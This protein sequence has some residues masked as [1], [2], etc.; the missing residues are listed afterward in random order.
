MLLL[1]GAGAAAAQGAHPFGVPESGA[2]MGGPGWLAGFF[3]QVSAWQS[4][5]YRQLTGA[6][7]AWQADGG[8]AWALI[9]LSFAYGVFHALGP[10]HGKA[11]ISSYVLA[12]RQTARNGALLALASALIQALVAIALVAVL[13]LVFN[14]TAATMNNATRWL[15]L[16]SYALVTLL[17]VW[18]VW[19]KA[20]RPLWRAWAGRAAEGAMLHQGHEHGSGH[21][22]SRSH[23]SQHVQA[24]A[25]H[26][27]GRHHDHDCGCGHVH[28]PAP[29]QVSGPLNWRRAGTAILAVG[30]RPCSGALIVLVFALAQGFFLAGVASALAMGLG[31]GLTVAALACLAV[32]AG[33]AATR[34]GSR[35]SSV[36]AARLR[37][38]VEALAALAVLLL[39]VMLL[40]GVIAGGG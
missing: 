5:F 16:G 36:G 8:A 6:V 25:H 1:G 32:A 39:G 40:G 21:A 7:R 2:G 19:V 18:L 22:R 13:A 35:L 38:G 17:G 4:H 14:A 20:V 10:G 24:Q 31:T 12:N 34:V 28:A 26:H 37:Y 23:E 9:G 11:V 30:L 3:G 15:E 27:H 33:G 29:E